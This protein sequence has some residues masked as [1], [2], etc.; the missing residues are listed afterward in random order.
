MLVK[1][2]DSETT[3]SSED[4]GASNPTTVGVAVM[5][6]EEAVTGSNPTTAAEMAVEEGIGIARNAT[7]QISPSEPNATGAVN[8]AVTPHP[9]HARIAVATAVTVETT[10]DGIGSVLKDEDAT[11]DAAVETGVAQSATIRI[12]PSEPNATDAVNLE[13][14][15]GRLPGT[16]DVVAIDVAA[17]K[18]G[19]T[20]AAVIVAVTSPN[21]AIGR[22][23]IV[24]PTISQAVR[25]ATSAVQTLGT[26]EAT[27]EGRDKAAVSEEATDVA[28]AKTV[29]SAK[30]TGRTVT[31]A[32]VTDVA[33]AK[34][35]ERVVKAAFDQRAP[36]RRSG[37]LEESLAG[38]PITVGQNPFADHAVTTIEGGAH[39]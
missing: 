5:T 24:V 30:E 39:G 17:S 20:N 15:L 8:L 2:V 29:V 16:T 26:V 10:V 4:E 25:P 14:T 19:T 23:T 3:G 38:T 11:I 9:N 27:D 37:K 1:K 12:S 36:G 35:V 7:T 18:E 31:D 13:E 34:T 28:H 22:A 21:P 32:V 6:D 33:H